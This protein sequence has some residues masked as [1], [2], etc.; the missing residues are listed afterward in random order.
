M[1]ICSKNDWKKDQYSVGLQTINREIMKQ[2]TSWSRHCFFIK[3]KV[4][5]YTLANC[6]KKLF[7][8]SKRFTCN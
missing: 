8:K 1:S 7:L 5:R 4:S 2:I 6:E 3:P